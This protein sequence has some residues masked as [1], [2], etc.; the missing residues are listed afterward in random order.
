[1]HTSDPA[2]RGPATRF[3]VVDADVVHLIGAR[4]EADTGEGVEGGHRGG[5]CSLLNQSW[6]K[7]MITLE[8]SQ[9]R[10]QDAVCLLYSEYRVGW[11]TKHGDTIVRFILGNYS[12]SFVGL[13]YTRSDL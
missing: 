11:Q 4:H 2:R 7:D 1:M 13:I 10:A 12:L 3:G 9:H 8:Y 6:K 5:D